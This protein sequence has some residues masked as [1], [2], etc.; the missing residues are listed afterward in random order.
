MSSDLYLL[1]R[2][3]LDASELSA[4]WIR[5]MRRLA[6]VTIPVACALAAFVAGAAWAK[7]NAA[8]SRLLPGQPVSA[9]IS[10]YH[11]R[12]SNVTRGPLASVP[13]HRGRELGLLIRAVNDLRPLSPGDRLPSC[14]APGAE[15][16][17][18]LIRFAY[19]NGDRLSLR[20][21]EYS[22]AWVSAPWFG[23]ARASDTL[24]RVI[25]ALLS[26]DLPA[27]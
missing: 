13:I 16:R 20:V 27:S 7:S 21:E 18:D 9:T 26:T 8:P 15:S 5:F 2:R 3:L 24:I 10:A 19:A 17:F 11:L 23:M 1:Q 4:T 22:C 25:D 12:A 14:P 6:V